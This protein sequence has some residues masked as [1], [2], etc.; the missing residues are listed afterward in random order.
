MIPSNHVLLYSTYHFIIYILLNY[1][2]YEM[3]ERWTKFMTRIETYRLIKDAS[4]AD[5]KGP[6]PM[7]GGETKRNLFLSFFFFWSFLYFF[8]HNKKKAKFLSLSLDTVVTALFFFLHFFHKKKGIEFLL[9]VVPSL[10]KRAI[11]F[12]F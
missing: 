8:I 4:S 10:V 9:W 11:S 1:E 5:D 7:G 2:N 12:I 3:S 6:H